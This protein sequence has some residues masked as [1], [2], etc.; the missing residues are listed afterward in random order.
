[1]TS[2]EG[3]LICELNQVTFLP[4]TW[5]KKF[6]RSVFR[7]FSDNP[8]KPLSEKQRHWVYRLA[9]KYRQQ[10]N[11]VTL[12]A[13]QIEAWCADNGYTEPFLFEYHWWA[14]PPNGVMP[15]PVDMSK[16]KFTSPV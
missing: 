11:Y 9:Y 15:V 12:V 13:I 1:M 8:D 3:V 14:Y 2:V 4:G 16:I 6:V 5:D 10:L 7:Q